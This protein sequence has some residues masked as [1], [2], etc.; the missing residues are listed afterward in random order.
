MKP[1]NFLMGVGSMANK[2][3]GSSIAQ[4]QAMGWVLLCTDKVIV[5]ALYMIH[6]HISGILM[7][8]YI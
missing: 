8:T 4:F 2:V 5:H 6:A 1:E 7:Y 3:C